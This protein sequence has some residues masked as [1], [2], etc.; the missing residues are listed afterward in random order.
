MVQDRSRAPAPRGLVFALI[1]TGTIVVNAGTDLMLPAVP[2]LPARLGGS[3]AT[4]QL[5][6]A[7]YVLG[8]ALGLIGFGELGARYARA[9]L[10]V[11][12]LLLFAVASLAAGLARSIDQLI[13]LRFV[14]GAL[15][16]APAV[17]APGLIRALYGEAGAVAA[18]G[19][20]GAAESVTPA[21]APLAGVALLR[22]WGWP[23]SFLLSGGLALV[24][25]ALI[26]RFR[27]MLP[28]APAGAT[29][30]GGYGRLLLDPVFSRYALSQACSV[31]SLIVFVFGAPAVF[32]RAL[33]LGLSAFVTL[34]ICGVSTFIASTSLSARLSVRYGVEPVITV[35]T[36]M[37]AAGFGAILAYALGGGRDP[38]VVTALFLIVNG[39]LGVRGPTGFNRAVVAARGDD[40]RGAALVVLG[41]L[42]TIAGGTA[43]AAPFIM[44]GLVPLAAIAT[45]IALAALLA[46]LLPRLE[47]V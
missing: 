4:A 22:L 41:I 2:S 10:L 13:V 12:S 37:M 35:G 3:A 30:G 36:G 18:I 34:Q 8:S 33:G 1:L 11:V 28:P 20:L 47:R 38:H 15:G 29:R 45:V 16:A 9:R 27:A 21:L 46:L 6:L 43:L 32:T 26:A 23:A 19:R 39:G 25:A 31:G 5:V 17:F 24:V 14:Q 44:R 7:T 42:G 40:T